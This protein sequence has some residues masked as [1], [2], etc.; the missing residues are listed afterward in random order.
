MMRCFESPE[1]CSL[2]GLRANVRIDDGLFFSR[3]ANASTRY[4]QC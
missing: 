1:L 4:T 2:L 3:N